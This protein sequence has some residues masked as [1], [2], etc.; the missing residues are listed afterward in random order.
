MTAGSANM[1]TRTWSKPSIPDSS[2]QA[3]T[4]MRAKAMSPM[5]PGGRGIVVSFLAIWKI[6]FH[7]MPF[8]LFY[9]HSKIY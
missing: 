1:G 7:K 4:S 8:I 6:I 3:V 9:E 2:S 5:P